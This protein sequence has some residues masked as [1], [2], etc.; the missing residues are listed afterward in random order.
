MCMLAVLVLLLGLDCALDLPLALT[1]LP[2]IICAFLHLLLLRHILV[3]LD[4]P[5]KETGVRAEPFVRHDRL[6]VGTELWVGYEHLAQEVAS[7]GGDVVWEGELRAEDIL[8]EEVDVVSFRIRRIVVEWQ[9]A[10]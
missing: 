3:L 1:D 7:L 8:V 10:R 4:A 5:P 9:V 6:Q 2:L